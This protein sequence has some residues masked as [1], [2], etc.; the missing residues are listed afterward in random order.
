MPRHVERAATADG[1]LRAYLPDRQ[2]RHG[3]GLRL[4][5]RGRLGQRHGPIPRRGRDDAGR[6]RLGGHRFLLRVCLGFVFFLRFFFR[7][8]F[9]LLRG[10]VRFLVDRLL[11]LDLHLLLRRVVRGLGGR[12]GVLPGEDRGLERLLRRGGRGLRRRRRG[13]GDRRGGHDVSRGSRWREARQV[14]PACHWATLGSACETAT[15]ASRT[16]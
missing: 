12:P 2:L 16:S 4:L 13:H 1:L 8:F 15:D 7:R 9:R 5:C 14:P 3:H 6:L 11:V 10:R